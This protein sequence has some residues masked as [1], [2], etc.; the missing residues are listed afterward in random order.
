LGSERKK[1]LLWKKILQRGA[2][3]QRLEKVFSPIGINIGADTPEEIAVSV[4]AEM[5]R[6]RRGV[7][8]EW[9]TK[10][11]EGVR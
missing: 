7:R 3:A 4:V 5:I 9:K 2:D 1:I 10:K 6:V 8:K 11:V